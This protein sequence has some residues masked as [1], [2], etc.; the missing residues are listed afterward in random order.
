MSEDISHIFKTWKFDPQED[1]TVRIIRG[2]DNR[3]KVQMRIEMGLMQMEIDG[4]PAGENPQGGESWLEYYERCQREYE[5]GAADDYFSLDEDDCRKLRREGVQYYYRYLSLMKIDDYQR[6]IRDTDRN[7]RLFAFVKKYAASE[8]DRWS[9]DQYR[10]YVIMMNTRARSSLI[11]KDNPAGGIDQAIECFDSGIGKII[12]FYNEYGIASEIENS[13]ELSILKSLKREFLRIRPRE[14]QLEE[15]LAQA[16]REERFED[17][18]KLRDMLRIKDM[19]DTGIPP[20]S[21][22]RRKPG[23]HK[24][25]GGKS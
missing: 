19:G 17:A 21:G 15:R 8:M 14:S 10:P 25:D 3:Q 2:D 22:S 1:I 5:A 7:L 6:V 11:L 9:L 4:H 12:A 16:V 24:N 20:L 18:A 13:M 23:G